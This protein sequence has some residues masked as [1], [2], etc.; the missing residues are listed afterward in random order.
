MALPI[1]KHMLEKLELLL[2][3]MGYRLRYE[4]G[5]FKTASCLLEHDKIIVVNKFS[6]LEVKILSLVSLIKNSGF[7]EA[8]LIDK[9]KE[10][11]QSLMQTELF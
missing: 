5:N 1:T 11:Y 6:N 2:L 8:N 9:Q 10:F 7:N 3:A 4:K